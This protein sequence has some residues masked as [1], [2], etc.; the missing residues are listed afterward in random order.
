MKSTLLLFILIVSL[1]IFALANNGYP[2]PPPPA[3]GPGGGQ[4]S[5][6]NHGGCRR[7]GKFLNG[8]CSY[9]SVYI[10]TGYYSAKNPYGLRAPSGYYSKKFPYGSRTTNRR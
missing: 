8:S 5:Y 9:P 6:Q 1:P 3:I 4:F 2:P 7:G 10:G